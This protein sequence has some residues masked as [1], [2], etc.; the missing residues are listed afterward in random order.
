MVPWASVSRIPQAGHF[1]P[2]EAPDALADVLAGGLPRLRNAPTRVM[3]Q[4]F[5]SEQ[6]GV[7][8]YAAAEGAYH[9]GARGS[10]DQGIIARL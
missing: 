8:S 3:G 2:M 9:A 1:I 6:E 7:A 10:R 5:D 4:Y